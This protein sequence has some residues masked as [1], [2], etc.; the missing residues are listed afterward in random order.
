MLHTATKA[1]ELQLTGFLSKHK[2]RLK[3]Y[4]LLT[5]LRSYRARQATESMFTY[6]NSNNS[7]YM[8]MISAQNQC[9]NSSDFRL[10]DGGLPGD[11]IA[12]G[13]DLGPL[14]ALQSRGSRLRHHLRKSITVKHVLDQ[15]R[16]SGHD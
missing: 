16:Y 11:H 6:R 15:T 13:D 7:N 5:K 1:Y 9:R 12:E 10:T 8:L 14:R 3:P 2:F 4:S